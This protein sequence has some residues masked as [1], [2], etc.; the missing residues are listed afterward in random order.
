MVKETL[1]VRKSPKKNYYYFRHHIDYILSRVL[2][3]LD[4][5]RYTMLTFSTLDSLLVMN[6]SLVRSKREYASA[7]WNSITSANSAK[8][9]RFQRKFAA[10]CYT[11]FLNSAST[12]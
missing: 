11:R 4:F 7:V 9:E 6:K 5:I 1:A 12:L 10:A 2:K 3:M 8:L